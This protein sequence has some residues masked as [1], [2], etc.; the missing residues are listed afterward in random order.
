MWCTPRPLPAFPLRR[1]PLLRVDYRI[2]PEA[3]GRMRIADLVLCAEFFLDK[4][5]CETCSSTLPILNRSSLLLFLTPS[6][7]PLL[8]S[9]LSGWPCRDALSRSPS[10]CAFGSSPHGSSS[11]SA[12]GCIPKGGIQGPFAF[13]TWLL[14]PPFPPSQLGHRWDRNQKQKNLA[15]FLASKSL[16]IS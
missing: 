7:A 15:C 9:L 5:S 6:G 2:L 16:G 11:D 10:T 13:R 3:L 14:H 1:C 8:S 12:A 4:V